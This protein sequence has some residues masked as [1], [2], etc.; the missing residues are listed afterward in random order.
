MVLER[1]GNLNL[2]IQPW[3]RRLITRLI[4]IIPA[5]LVILISGES[6]TGELLIFSQVIL[7]LQLGFAIIP[8]IHFVSNREKM[9]VFAIGKL[10]KFTAWLIALI[11]V[12]LNV[13]LVFNEL[14]GWLESAGDEAYVLWLTVVPVMIAAFCF[15]WKF[16][17]FFQ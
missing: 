14:L 3:L 5:L 6:K 17:Q 8:L 15:K 1:E 2:R 10:T 16:L 9:G 7:S 11:I 13:N 4:A 12:S